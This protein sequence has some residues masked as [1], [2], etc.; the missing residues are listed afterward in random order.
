MSDK[1]HTDL[2]TKEIYKRHA[3]M[4]EGG[5]MPRAKVMD[6]TLIDRYLMDGLLTLQEHQA[7]EYVLNQGSA[8]G[9]YVKPLKFEASTGGKRS[10][11]PMANDA[12]MRFGRTLKLVSD[13][14]GEYHKYLVQEV[15][16]HEWDVSADSKKL[17]A[18]KE[19][20]SWIADRRMAG[21][22]NPVRHLRQ[23]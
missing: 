15:V 20:L 8:A 23:R 1:S 3:V 7:A 12:L 22:R 4:V 21:G 19:G 14:F 16:I 6:Q 13:R 9:L 5:N 10:E 18:L 17:K 2:G 11:D